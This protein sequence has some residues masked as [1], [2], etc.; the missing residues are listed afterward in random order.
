MLCRPH[1]GGAGHLPAGLR[2]HQVRFCSALPGTRL[3][4][5]VLHIDFDEQ[6]RVSF[7]QVCTSH[8][9]MILCCRA[10]LYKLPWD[11]TTLGH[12]QTNP[13][14]VLQKV[15]ATHK[16]ERL[17][18]MLLLNSFRRVTPK[19]RV[20]VPHQTSVCYYNR[21]QRSFGRRPTP[22]AAA[23]GRGTPACG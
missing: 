6:N 14:F 13:L 17:Q 18:C 11:M 1:S 15:C 22:S 7:H 2:E 5:N 10:G 12:R 23:T 16:T 9:S 3:P 19:H 8:N 21:Q 4:P 20:T